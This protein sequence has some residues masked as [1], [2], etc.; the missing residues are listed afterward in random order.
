MFDITD[1]RCNYELHF[2]CSKLPSSS[3]TASCLASRI[4]KYSFSRRAVC[5]YKISVCVLFLLFNNFS[6]QM[7]KKVIYPEYHTNT[8]AC[9]SRTAVVII[10]T[11]VC[12][13]VY[14]HIYGSRSSDVGIDTAT[15]LWAGRTG[16]RLSLILNDQTGHGAHLATNSMG[17][18]LISQG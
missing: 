4:R 5:R 12:V 14:I 17:T 13:C 1:A 8:R 16:V 3:S 18:G 11:V 6:L 2:V 15:R 9:D 7:I 10:T